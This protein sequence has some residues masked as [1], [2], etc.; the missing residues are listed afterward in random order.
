MN[1]K[2][3]N[4]SVIMILLIITGCDGPTPLISPTHYDRVP[5]PENLTAAADTTETGKKKITLSWQISEPSKVKSYDLHRSFTGKGEFP[6]LALS[7]SRTIYTDSTIAEGRDSVYY[8]I[9]AKGPDNFI[10]KKSDT[11]FVFFNS[12]N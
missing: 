5:T 3:F 4:L 1:L 8:F 2:Y 11:L 6:T 7:Y 9:V 12:L 10:G